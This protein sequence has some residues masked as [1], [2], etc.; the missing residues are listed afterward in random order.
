MNFEVGSAYH[1]RFEDES[2]D[3]VISTGVI[4]DLANPAKALNE[5]YRVL[6]SGREA[7]VYD[8]ALIVPREKI[9]IWY[10]RLEGEELALFK[11]YAN[12]TPPRTYST[13]ELE[14]IL[15][16]TKFKEYEIK[17]GEW[18]RIKLKK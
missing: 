10:E 14:K 4:H 16:E 6:K 9:K 17:R 15:S 18:I 2:F 5:W 13:G 8:P 3:T 1:L 11:E 7:L 12:R